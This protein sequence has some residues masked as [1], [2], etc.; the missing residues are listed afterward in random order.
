MNLIRI[1]AIA[2]FII[3]YYVFIFN[4]DHVALCGTN[5]ISFVVT[6]VQLV[7]NVL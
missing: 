5:Y 2:S 7:I 3:R 4:E 1:L 6:L